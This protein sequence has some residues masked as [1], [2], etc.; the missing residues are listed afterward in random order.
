VNN[1]TE[2][3]IRNV[4]GS[5]ELR[6]VTFTANRL[7]CPDHDYKEGCVSCALLN[8]LGPPI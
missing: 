6:F 5:K 3:V 8:H 1:V 7:E 2:L 4:I